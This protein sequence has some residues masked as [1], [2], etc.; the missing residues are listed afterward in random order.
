MGV[1]NR[2]IVDDMT[3]VVPNVKDINYYY[4]LH[5]TTVSELAVPLRIG[6]EVVG[7]LNAE[8]PDPNAFD[9]DLVLILEAMAAQTS[10]GVQCAALYSDLRKIGGFVGNKTALEW[11]SIV[12][13]NWAHDI[14]RE[15]GIARGKL[16]VLERR[17]KDVLTP[18]NRT[19]LKSLDCSFAKLEEIRLIAPLTSE[20]EVGEVNLCNFLTKYTQSL[21][22]EDRFKG[23]DL[24]LELL[25][26]TGLH[27]VRAS[28]NWL[29]RLFDIIFDNGIR[30]LR[31]EAPEKPI[32]CLTGRADGDM[33]QIRIRNNGPVIPKDLQDKL[34]V[35]T[36]KPAEGARGA[37]IGLVLART[38][39]ESYGGRLFLNKEYAK[40]VEFTLILPLAYGD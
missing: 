4:A 21:L 24:N 5:P 40:G 38:I 19:Y 17:L 36:I 16:A 9:D 29:R 3:V 2:C 20:D 12:A 25:E 8:H 6:G 18:N 39:A 10:I 23:I 30:A 1:M 14:K 13:T 33:A 35:K 15:V 32:F 22:I 7:V 34:F 11:M 26:L 28:K 37:G 31:E 27:P